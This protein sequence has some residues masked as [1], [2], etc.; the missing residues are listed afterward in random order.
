MTITAG[1][2]VDVDNLLKK[3]I[4]EIDSINQLPG[5]L[6]QVELLESRLIPVDSQGQSE[7]VEQFGL[8]LDTGN[9]FGSGQHPSTRLALAALAYLK[10][11]EA[12]FPDR[13]LD[14]GC[15]SGILSL[16]SAWCGASRIQG[17][18]ISTEAIAIARRNVEANGFAR[19]IAISDQ[20]FDRISTCYDLITANLTASVLTRL[21]PGF[22]G[23]LFAK[24]YLIV[25]GIQGRQADA[26][27]AILVPTG[28]VVVKAFATGPWRA[29]LYQLDASADFG[30]ENFVE[31]EL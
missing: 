18:D 27:S 10:E 22:A 14:V 25:A 21:A 24:G 20:P 4:Q 30:P 16:V 8:A 19:S 13:V 26:I 23:R 31:L 7:S 11:A 12:V 1:S 29:V 15:G 2:P 28:F 6:N 5:M 9:V 17:I 3:I